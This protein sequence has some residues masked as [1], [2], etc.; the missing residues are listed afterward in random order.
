[1]A[2][3]QINWITVAVSLASSLISAGFA[4]LLSRRKTKAET[5]KLIAE[6]KK[7]N[8]EAEKIRLEMTKLLQD[9]SSLSEKIDI[10]LSGKSTEI[11]YYGNKIRLVLILP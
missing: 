9:T 7:L 3:N 2:D 8:A 6:A 10:N 11:I 5:E 4:S 1:M